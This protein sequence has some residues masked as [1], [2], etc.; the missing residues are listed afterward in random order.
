M[1]CQRDVLNVLGDFENA[2]FA[3]SEAQ[4][5]DPTNPVLKSCLSLYE[6]FLGMRAFFS[7]N[8]IA[9]ILFNGVLN[10]KESTI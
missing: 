4:K 5:L 9:L 6:S 1:S 2:F 3:Y 8:F 10:K 7:N